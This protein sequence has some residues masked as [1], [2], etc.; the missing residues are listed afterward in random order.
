M[1]VLKHNQKIKKIFS[2]EDLFQW[3]NAAQYVHSHESDPQH[4][5]KRLFLKFRSIDS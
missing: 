4:G 2:A 3:Q 5:K 1:N